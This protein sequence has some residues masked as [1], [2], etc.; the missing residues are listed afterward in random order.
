VIE[1]FLQGYPETVIADRLHHQLSNVEHYI[2]D[3]L[4]VSLLLEDGYAVGEAG[5]LTSL[6]KGKVQAIHGLYTR[7]GQEAFYQPLLAR[8]LALFRFDRRVVEKGGT[9]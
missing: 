3:F 5:R 1:L 2:R 9:A 8:T 4:R 6:S 7:L